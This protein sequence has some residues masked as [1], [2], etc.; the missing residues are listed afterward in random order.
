MYY[1][2]MQIYWY[3]IMLSVLEQTNKNEKSEARIEAL[4]AVIRKQEDTI[5]ELSQR[6]G[7]GLTSTDDPDVK[8]NHESGESNRSSDVISRSK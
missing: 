5:A 6:C 4:E 7:D 3:Q 2:F 8:A 1:L